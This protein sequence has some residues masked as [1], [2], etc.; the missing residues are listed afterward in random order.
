MLEH[1]YSMFIIEKSK[2]L[3]SAFYIQKYCSIGL[4]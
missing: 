4:G 2:Y 1:I 3:E